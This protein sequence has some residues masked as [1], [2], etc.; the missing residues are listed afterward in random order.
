MNKAAGWLGYICAVSLVAICTLVGFAMTPRFDVVNVAMVYLLAVVIIAL[1]FS[2]W[3]AIASAVLSVAAFDL[4]FV[5]PPGTFTISDLQYLLTFFIMLVVAL[6]ISRLMERGKEQA[7]EQS[8]LAIEAESEANRRALLASISHDLRTPLA[9]LMGAS[10]SLVET[11]DRMDPEERAALA[12]SI[13][14]RTCE[15]TDQVDKILQM[16][17]IESGAIRLDLEWSSIA[18]LAGAALARLSG[19]LAHHHVLVEIP[20]DLPLIH[21][22]ATLI[23][24]VLVNLLEN[25]ARHTPAGTIVRL[26][27]CLRPEDL[28]V[29]VED[30]GPGIEEAEIARLFVKFSHPRAAASGSGVGLGLAICRALLK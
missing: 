15:M 6:V 27:A 3:A 9:V 25:A 7:Q 16:T 17:R 10:S 5:P 8:K 19:H 12:A 26:R 2:R 24:Q 28:A 18:E 21:V 29:S 22:D 13:Y 4:S 30:Y 11:G 1:T 14:S 23:E 20:G